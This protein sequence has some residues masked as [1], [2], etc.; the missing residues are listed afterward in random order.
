MSEQPTKD[1][2]FEEI[3]RKIAEEVRRLDAKP[4]HIP[5]YVEYGGLRVVEN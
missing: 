3:M 4:P 2:Q 1:Q 5:T